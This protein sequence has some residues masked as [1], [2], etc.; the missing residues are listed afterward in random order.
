MIKSYL[1]LPFMNSF[2]VKSDYKAK[3]SVKLPHIQQKI[4]WNW[5][6]LESKVWKLNIQH[7]WWYKF[8]NTTGSM[9]ET[10]T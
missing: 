9:V 3:V 6:D 10:Y 8:V 1:N 4:T 7:Q 2:S 5:H